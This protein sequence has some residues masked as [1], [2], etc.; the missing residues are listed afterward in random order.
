MMISS[1]FIIWRGSLTYTFWQ[2]IFR[3]SSNCKLDTTMTR[4]L[5]WVYTVMLSPLWKKKPM[6]K[7]GACYKKPELSFKTVT[8]PNASDGWAEDLS[9]VLFSVLHF[10]APN[11]TWNHHLFKQYL[12]WA[13]PC[14][15]RH[16]SL[17]GGGIIWVFDESYSGPNKS[18]CSPNGSCCGLNG[19]SAQLKEEIY[20]WAW[21]ALSSWT[22]KQL[23]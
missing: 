16:C 15:A 2:I 18:C 22:Q 12:M 10:G 19:R 7:R 14:D 17:W 11:P 13:S 8:F 1:T 4:R 23:L 21:I 20:E 5:V 9:F 6:L 3:V